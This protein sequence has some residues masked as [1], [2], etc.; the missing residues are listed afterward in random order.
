M[1][2]LDRLRV[3]G[4]DGP[5]TTPGAWTY[6]A[7][8]LRTFHDCAR[9]WFFN[10]VLRYP[11]PAGP[12]AE[13]GKSLHK[14]VEDYIREGTDPE[15][16]RAWLLLRNLGSI[17]LARED[18]TVEGHIKF[19]VVPGHEGREGPRFQGFI[20]LTV[21]PLAQERLRI[22]DHKTTSDLKWAK[23]EHELHHD[24]QMV[25]YAHWAFARCPDMDEVEVIHSYVQTKGVPETRVVKAVLTRAEVA[26]RWAEHVKLIEKM[27]QVRLL[28]DVRKVSV[29]LDACGKYGGCPHSGACARAQLGQ[30][31]GMF[32]PP[33]AAEPGR[34][35]EPQMDQAMK[36]RLAALR[37]KASGGDTPAPTPPEKVEEKLAE[38]VAQAPDTAPLS[39]EEV[40][41]K[42]AELVAQAP[43]PL[44]PEVKA[45]GLGARAQRALQELGVTTI[46]DLL[47]FDAERATEVQGVGSGAVDQIK[48]AQDTLRPRENETVAE[49]STINEMKARTAEVLGTSPV[50]EPAL[51]EVEPEVVEVS[52]IVETVAVDRREGMTLSAIT[53]VARELGIKITIEVAP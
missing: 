50:P 35:E 51:A 26:E 43:A 15:D 34:E 24:I 41:E 49:T 25:S 27:E 3:L 46:E 13:L 9:K 17:D 8:Q 4:Q 48:A 14:Q 6:S 18:L 11:D 53:K 10:K 30:E 20:D 37:A 21:P 39:S 16:E 38:S 19:Q 52:E 22:V 1:T 36:D 45:L 12:A 47:E 23:S 28:E 5:E 32:N 7:S 29:N 2:N 44:S 31:V 42:L 33:D 40:D